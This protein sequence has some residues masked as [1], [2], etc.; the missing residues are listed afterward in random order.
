MVLLHLSTQLAWKP[1]HLLSCWNFSKNSQ[2]PAAFP[3]L[4]PTGV[5]GSQLH[6]DHSHRH[7]LH[8][9]VIF[10][11][12]K[13]TTTK[14]HR[15]TFHSHGCPNIPMKFY[16]SSDTCW[17]EWREYSLCSY[18]AEKMWK[19]KE[20]E[21]TWTLQFPYLI[22]LQTRDLLSQKKWFSAS[23]ITTANLS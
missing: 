2:H 1:K 16:K 11:K 3:T 13:G 6:V 21:E 12:F 15:V 14:P 23:H 4:I 8:V 5:C 18:F 17:R 7:S 19:S 10:W 20:Q 9:G 22:F